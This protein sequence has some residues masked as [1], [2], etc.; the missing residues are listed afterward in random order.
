MAYVVIK[1]KC[2]GCEACVN[3]CP[4][5]AIFDDNETMY[6]EDSICIECGACESVCPT[7]AII[8]K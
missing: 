1:E 8:F 7:Q 5:N 2:I 4:V 6:I 3:A